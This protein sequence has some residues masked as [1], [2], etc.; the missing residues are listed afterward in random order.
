MSQSSIETDVSKVKHIE[1]DIKSFQSHFH[2]IKSNE[3]LEIIPVYINFDINPSLQIT[4]TYDTYKENYLTIREILLLQNVKFTKHFLVI[5][6]EQ[7]DL[8]QSNILKII[9]SEDLN[10]FGFSSI[11]IL[12]IIVL[13][14]LFI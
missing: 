12:C 2:H 10:F 4:K 14:K 5:T 3:I 7:F 8:I 1:F 13:I 11:I 6:Y 9:K